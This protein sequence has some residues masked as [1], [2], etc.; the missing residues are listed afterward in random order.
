M[1][2][3]QLVLAK[4]DREALIFCPSYN[5][6][7]HNQ[8]RAEGL[9]FGRASSPLSAN[10]KFL[11]LGSQGG[12]GGV[13]GKAIERG[14]QLTGIKSFSQRAGREKRLCGPVCVTG[15]PLHSLTSLKDSTNQVAYVQRREP[16]VI[17][18]SMGRA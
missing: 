8:K 13:G 6:D 11:L 2:P 16:G 3:G 7:S 9:C 5:E 15:V 12:G 18:P 1:F 10:F 17:L 4:R 14:V